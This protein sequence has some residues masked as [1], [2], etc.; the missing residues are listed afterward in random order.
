M[1]LRERIDSLIGRAHTDLAELVA[2]PSVA[3]PEQYPPENCRRAAEW[4]AA[5]FAA[6]GF[7]DVSLE[8]TSD[9]SRA[10]YGVRPAADPAAPTTDLHGRELLPAA[11]LTGLCLLLGV[12]PQPLLDLIRPAVSA[13]VHDVGGPSHGI[14]PVHPTSSTDGGN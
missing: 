13:I 3:D 14:T 4:V 2:I 7:T 11:V 6:E 5:R 1:D 10:V 12:Y 9:G 8:E